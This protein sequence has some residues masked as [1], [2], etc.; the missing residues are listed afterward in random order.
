MESGK[1]GIHELAT[2]IIRTP[3]CGAEERWDAFGISWQSRLLLKR[4]RRPTRRKNISRGGCMDVPEG[5][6][7]N[8]GRLMVF[9]NVCTGVWAERKTEHIRHLRVG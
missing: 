5:L 8:R 2:R 6:S 9:D 4:V 1:R 3:I 7:E